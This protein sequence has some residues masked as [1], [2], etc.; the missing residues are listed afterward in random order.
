MVNTRSHQLIYSLLQSNQLYLFIIINQTIHH[1]TYC[2]R[3]SHFLGVFKNFIFRGNWVAQSV[4]HLPVAQVLILWCWDRAPKWGSL[5]I[6][7]SASP[8]PCPCTLAHS[9]APALFLK[10]IKHLK[11]SF[12]FLD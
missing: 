5:P 6:E 7:E 2:F 3:V 11:N 10:E 4:K 8:S 1:P 9:S 12:S